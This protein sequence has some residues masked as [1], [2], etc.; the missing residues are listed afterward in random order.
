MRDDRERIK[1]ILE[2][3]TLIEKYAVKGKDAFERDE[4]IQTWILHHLLVL[5]EAAAKVSDDF[6]E[7]HAHIPWSQIVGMRNI[8]IHH[9]FGID[10][11]VVWGMIEKDLPELKKTMMNLS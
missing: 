3:I 8:L 2:A 1:D 6:Q 11:Q 10:L 7:Q 4:L 5:G 9:Y